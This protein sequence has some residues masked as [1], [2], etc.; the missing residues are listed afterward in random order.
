MSV[1]ENNLPGED[2]EQVP[3]SAAN[4]YGAE[5]QNAQP[6]EENVNGGGDSTRELPQNAAL[7]D[8]A[9]RNAELF[10]APDGQAYGTVEVA[11]HNETYPVESTSFKDWL[12]MQFFRDR[13]KA[14]SSGALTDA[15]NTIRA[16]ATFD[17]EE[18]PVYVRVAQH[19]GD[20][21]IDL[22][23]DAWEAIQVTPL[24][25]Q[26]I[27]DPPVKFIRSKNSASLPYPVLGG[28]VEELKRFLNVDEQHYRLVVGWLIG[29][30][31]PQGP[32]PVLEAI[33]WQGTSKST[34]TRLLVSVSDPAVVPLRAL[35]SN[36][37]DLAIAASRSW[38]LSFDNV[39]YIR[40]EISDAMCRLSTG[41]GFGTR[42]LYSDDEEMIFDAKRPQIV[43][44][45][46]PVVFRGDL[47][48]RS[49]QVL[50]HPIPPDE[51][52]Q[53]REF[54]KEFEEARPRIFGAL[55]DV[56]SCALRK[57][58]EV[59][60][61]ESP[62]MADFA[63]WVTAAEEVLG[64]EPGDFMRAYEG[65]RREASEALLENDPVATAIRE[66]LDRCPGGEWSGTSEKLLEKLNWRATEEIMRTKAWP[67]APNHLSRH[68]NRIA[69]A[70]REAG[71]EYLQHEEGREKRKIKT[72]RKTGSAGGVDEGHEVAEDRGETP[73]GISP[74]TED[75]NGFVS[76]ELEGPEEL[77]YPSELA[78]LGWVRAQ[79]IFGTED[80][81]EDDPLHGDPV[82][83]A[84]RHGIPIYRG[85]ALDDR[86]EFDDNPWVVTAE[87]V[88]NLEAEK[89]TAE[90]LRTSGWPTTPEEMDARL[91]WV[92][93]LLVAK[94]YP[95]YDPDRAEWYSGAMVKWPTDP[96]KLCNQALLHA[97]RWVNQ[98]TSEALW[99]LVAFQKGRRPPDEAIERA[100]YYRVTGGGEAMD[101]EPP[102]RYDFRF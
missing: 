20:V 79:T 74:D 57:R 69:P 89:K 55:L 82:A 61:E 37:R 19:G 73:E 95:F 11:E 32:Y 60:L 33:G 49:L 5:S 48:E 75:E 66:L 67:K 51:R 96:E 10:H 78:K 34:L 40:S 27:S 86:C 56:V 72:L 71:I 76:D 91:K 68:L 94:P 42:K 93:P 13:S 8:Y 64:W 70:L 85:H 39:S 81:A 35:P 59:R 97:E 99:T 29:A 46:N 1:N 83:R 58:D 2:Q 18:M 17:G 31:N 87:D 88:L 14:P 65:N 52:R 63:A 12:V 84:L 4:N 36:E 62:R 54:W 80:L 30:F 16:K 98:E 100:V 21:Y 23:N 50:L 45:I 28:S 38:T 41:G 53:E 92:L 22:A 47:Q 3:T 90:E 9:D 43:N 24:G 102:D 101:L 26:V 6:S 77:D 15:L 7:V 25:W 44:G